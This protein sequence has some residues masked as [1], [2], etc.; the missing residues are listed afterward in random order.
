[1]SSWLPLVVVKQAEHR[2]AITMA[3]KPKAKR[4]T[5]RDTT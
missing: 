1:M 3:S 4:F 5:R 2:D